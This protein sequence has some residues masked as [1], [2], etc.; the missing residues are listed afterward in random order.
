MNRIVIFA[1]GVIS[2]SAAIQAH[3]RPADRFF[4]AN[5]GTLH[6]LA[7]GLT[8]ETIIGDLD[9]LP[10]DTV[11]EMEDR[12]VVV[13]RYPVSKDKTD[14]ELAFDLALAEQPDEILL[15]G[16]LGGRLD[17]T[18]ANL[19]LLTRPEFAAIRVSVVD[20]PQVMTLLHAH[21]RLTVR[22]Q[23]GDTLSLVPLTP[24]VSGVTLTGVE[25]P[26]EQAALSLGSTL[27]IS[28]MLVAG[29]ATVQIAEGLVFVVHL[30]KRYRGEQ[31]I[32][33]FHH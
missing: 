1:N 15:L 7:L 33:D 22:G 19:L 5:G 29:E 12:G 14:L 26:L 2:D 13:H 31:S 8:P 28:N 4:C 9:S 16:A 3:L 11:A 6:A 32:N 25:W 17:Q 18:L 24:L 21:Q 27:S 30:Q 20:G 10:P 23:A